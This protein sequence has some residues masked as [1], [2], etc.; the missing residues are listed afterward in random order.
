M[1]KHK[2]YEYVLP[3]DEHRLTVDT[4][5][6]GTLDAITDKIPT[7]DVREKANQAMNRKELNT[8][9]EYISNEYEAFQ[10]IFIELYVTAYNEKQERYMK[11]SALHAS[12]AENIAS[13]GSGAYAHIREHMEKMVRIAEGKV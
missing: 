4:I 5:S 10:K 12:E 6:L 9:Y 2:K 1:K 13:M 11:N 3:G 8:E 7:D